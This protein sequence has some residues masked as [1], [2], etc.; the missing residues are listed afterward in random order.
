[1]CIRDRVRCNI[2]KDT[3]GFSKRSYPSYELHLTRDNRFIILGRKMKIKPP[4]KYLITMNMQKICKEEPEYLGKLKSN[5]TATEFNVY[6]KGKAP[7][8]KSSMQETRNQYASIV[9]SRRSYNETKTITVH[10]P[11]IMEGNKALIWKVHVGVKVGR[12]NEGGLG[13]A[14]EQEAE[15]ECR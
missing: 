12:G 6:G 10:I 14:E 8:S 11:K 5:I 9:Y 4:I 7:D 1:M 13:D 2:R 3:E 15:V